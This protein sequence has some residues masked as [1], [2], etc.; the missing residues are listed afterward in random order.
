MKSRIKVTLSFLLILMTIA[1]SGCSG[2]NES[3]NDN[4][5]SQDNSVVVGIQQDLDSLDPHK[6]VAAGTNEV[7]FNI[8]EG[9]V[10]PDEEGNL[11]PCVASEYDIS[12]DGLTYTFT[13]RDN[14]KFHNGAVVTVEDIVY[15][16]ERSAG[17]LKGEDTSSINIESALKNIKSVEAKDDKTVVVTLEKPNTELIAYFTLAIIPKDY[18]DQETAPVG[19]GPFS[20]KSYTPLESFVMD[21]YSDYW[22]QDNQA[23]L[24]EVT[25]KIVSSTDDA[26]VE[27]LAGSIDI[28]PYLTQDQADQLSEGDTFNVESGNMNLVQ[29]LFLNNDAA[30]FN[31]Q[32]LRE[33]LNYAIDK[34]AILDM[35]AGGKGSVI[36]SGLFPGMSTY[37]DDTAKD[38]YSYDV[39]KA[40]ALL[41]EAGYPD[42]FAFTITV[43][44]NYSFHVSTAEVIVEQFKAVGITAS[45]KQVEWNNWLDDVYK[46]GNYQATIIGLEG[47][48]A[49]SDLL[50]RYSST[51][52]N[53]FIHYVNKDYDKTLEKATATT[54]EKEKENYYKQLQQLLAKDSASVFIQDPPLLVAVNKQLT[55][56]TFYPVYVQDMSKVRYVD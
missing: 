51:A 35:V 20:F 40:K 52:E 9:L 25:F 32:Q 23:Y 29:G 49:P 6:A 38:M 36:G 1:L 30:P 16:I 31:N 19:T 8:F 34:Q 46:G 39:E 28:F 10:K 5:I 48:L 11:V 27:L 54:D 21:K 4:N 47:V 44:S 18:K 55:G 45:I 12:E 14:V 13:L 42:G 15:S 7:L 56:Y 50:T 37:Y 53:N 26:F 41:T 24:D 33:V 22:N 17:L 2:D 3:K 43:P